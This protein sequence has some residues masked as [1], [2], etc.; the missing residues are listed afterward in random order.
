V[1][2]GI[3]LLRGSCPILECK[4]YMEALKELV[5]EPEGIMSTFSTGDRDRANVA[6][7]KSTNGPTHSALE[8]PDAGFYGFQ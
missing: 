1:A 6:I 4:L 5:F 8:H 2:L 3:S 7:G